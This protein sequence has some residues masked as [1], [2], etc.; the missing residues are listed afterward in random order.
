MLFRKGLSIYLSFCQHFCLSLSWWLLLKDCWLTWFSPVPELLGFPAS[1]LL[2]SLLVNTSSA[3][4]FP[5]PVLI[6]W[7]TF[8]GTVL[9]N[10]KALSHLQGHGFFW[11]HLF[12]IFR[13]RSWHLRH[14][15]SHF[16]RPPVSSLAVAAVWHVHPLKHYLSPNKESN[17]IC[18]N[19]TSSA[20][21]PCISN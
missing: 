4:L 17:S 1:H 9:I 3:C 12:K 7:P 13:R 19:L 6:F 2:T 11:R 14:T 10:S 15:Q 18:R 5:Q 8:F 16:P 20:R 21:R